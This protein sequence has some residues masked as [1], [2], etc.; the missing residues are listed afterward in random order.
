[1]LQTLPE[2]TTPGHNMQYFS[3]FGL[4]LLLRGFRGFWGDFSSFISVAGFFFN[5]SV[6]IEKNLGFD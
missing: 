1:M 2:S 3:N 5:L 6:N 4:Y